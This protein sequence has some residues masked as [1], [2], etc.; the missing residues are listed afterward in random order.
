[1]KI[2]DYSSLIFAGNTTVLLI[3]SLATDY[4]EY[5]TFDKTKILE[6]I[7]QSINTE[8]V[9]PFD[10][11]SYFQIKISSNSTTD[12][13]EYANISSYEEYY[14]APLFFIRR[15]YKH[16]EPNATMMTAEVVFEFELDL[17][18]Q[19][20]NLFRDCDALEGILIMILL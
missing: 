10:T 5:R 6:T 19:Y 18:E 8:I 9:L 15:S 3:V 11:D 1:M 2:C 17:F 14:H 7:S 16:L 13:T 4:W 20:G 12:L